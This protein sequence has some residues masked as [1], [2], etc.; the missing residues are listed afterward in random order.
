[1]TDAPP[2]NGAHDLLDW[3]AHVHGCE[4]L[5]DDWQSLL[6]ELATRL[7]ACHYLLR[8]LECSTGAI[9]ECI[10]SLHNPTTRIP[11]NADTSPRLL[12][13]AP[14][15]SA[16][17]VPCGAHVLNRGFVLDSGIE[18]SISLLRMPTSPAFDDSATTLF[19]RL[20]EHVH[21]S[22]QPHHDRQRSSEQLRYHELTLEQAQLAVFV[23]DASA[24]LWHV[25]PL[26]NVLLQRRTL[27]QRHSNQLLCSDP[28]DTA[29]LH[30]LLRAVQ[31]SGQ[32]ES[33]RFRE[34]STGAT[35]LANILPVLSTNESSP[36]SRLL[37]TA[38]VGRRCPTGRQL[39]QLF[40]FTAAEAR[41]AR[42]L[43]AG[44]TPSA[45][46]LHCELSIATV[47]S[48]LRATLSKSGVGRQSELIALL[49]EIPVWR[50]N[51]P[52]RPPPAMGGFRL[53]PDAPGVPGPPPA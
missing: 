18:Y 28:T 40:G 29:R 41:L 13:P 52:R 2:T 31:A 46:A 49:G 44:M 48:Q 42:A 53:S 39:M 33:L 36:P 6:S 12:T 27:L 5:R 30:A 3:L 34:A 32:A 4:F 7:G 43:A 9:L 47:R 37:L 51:G 22:L 50:S 45:Y 20:I 10:T 8:V 23:C 14:E 19:A 17:A 35:L 1:M 21:C 15:W 26:G 24:H 16:G 11:S 38:R 25:N